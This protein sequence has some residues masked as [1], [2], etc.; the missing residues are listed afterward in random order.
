LWQPAKLAAR[1]QAA[2]TSGR[3]VLLRA[4]YEGGH[5][6]AVNSQVNDDLADGYAFLVWQLS[7]DASQP[8]P[9]VR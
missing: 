4:E 7:D 6:D 1:L 8:S 3:P 5:L 9:A 2:T